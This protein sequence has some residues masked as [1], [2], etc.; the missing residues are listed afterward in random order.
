MRSLL[1]RHLGDGWLDRAADPETWAGVDGIPDEE[2]WAA[3]NAARRGLVEYVQ[4]KSVQDR[5]LRGEDPESVKAV[6]ETF[7]GRHADARLRAPDRD[8][9]AALP[10]H[11]TTPSA[12]G[13]SSPTAR[14]CSWSSPA[15]PIR[16]TT[17]R[18]RCSSTRSRSRTQSAS[19]RA[20]RS[21][22]TTTS[23]SPRPSSVA[24]TC[25]STC[26]G[27]RSR[28]VGRAG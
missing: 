25:G 22:R 17:R 14:P 9:Q 5:L 8:V 19:P 28:R 27:R 3:R 11:A 13:G 1:D 15:R 24:A 10:A 18:S 12:C 16:S 6:A 7:T 26:R 2:L 21:S 20:A 4:A 23:R